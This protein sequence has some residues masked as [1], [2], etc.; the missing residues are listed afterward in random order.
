MK[1]PVRTDLAREVPRH[2]SE[3]HAIGETLPVV[4]GRVGLLEE[5]VLNG[6]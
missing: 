2:V 5:G 3:A 1:P 6:Q 4:R